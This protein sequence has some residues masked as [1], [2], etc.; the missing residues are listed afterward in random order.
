MA[1]HG[2]V[3]SVSYA[4]ADV[5]E[6]FAGA[7]PG[8]HAGRYARL[9]VSDTGQGM[10]QQTL[11]RIFDPF[12]T[13]KAPGEGTGLGLAVVHGI[14]Q[15]HGGVAAVRST[16]GQ[17]TTFDLYFPAVS[18]SAMADVPQEHQP[19]RG[20]G[21]HVL[22]VDDE[23]ALVKISRRML[24]QLGYRVTAHSQPLQALAAFEA[25]PAAFDLLLCDLTM[26]QMTGL[27]FTA[28]V[29]EIR[30]EL[31]VVL[32]SGYGG[33]LDTQ[34]MQQLG[35]RELVQKPYGSRTLAEAIARHLPRP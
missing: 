17:G 31:P 13:T 10:D 11:N 9:S 32:T 12:F 27:D 21:E 33:A 14:M 4:R 24:E 35:I 1:E 29:R 3:L 28:R 30:P 5:D 19:P 2:G 20:N 7:H 15:S 18:G 25:E 6:A 26:P 34:D 23:P 16:P 22:V 8:M